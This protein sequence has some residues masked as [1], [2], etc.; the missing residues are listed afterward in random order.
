VS[1]LPP[2]PPAR[3]QAPARAGI[4]LE[5]PPREADCSGVR[6]SWYPFVFNVCDIDAPD[7]EPMTPRMM[8]VPPAP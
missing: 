7:P 6:P 4:G 3:V 5:I 8:R 2:Y 1:P